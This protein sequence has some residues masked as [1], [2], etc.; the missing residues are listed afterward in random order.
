MEW[1]SSEHSK[2]K[3]QKS[4]ASAILHVFIALSDYF[5]H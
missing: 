5:T 4:E 2:N 3:K 1:L